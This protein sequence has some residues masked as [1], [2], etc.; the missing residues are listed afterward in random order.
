MHAEVPVE[1]VGE[2]QAIKDRLGV[3][4]TL[5]DHVEV[6]ALPAHLPEK[7]TIDISHLTQVDEQVTVQN[8]VVPSDV[9]VLTD[10]T[11]IVAKIGAFVVEKEPEPVVPAE[12]AETAIPEGE[13]KEGEEEA[14]T[15]QTKES[16][17]EK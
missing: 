4:L 5:I 1:C 10:K 3:L 6:E 14:P 12:G 11:L 8:L 9:T 16:P 17:Q 13:T 2:P 15:T 7:I